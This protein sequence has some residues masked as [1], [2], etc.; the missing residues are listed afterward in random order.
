MGGWTG[1]GAK[2]TP[3]DCSVVIG[4]A[5]GL[6][7]A[8]G[9]DVASSPADPDDATSPLGLVRVDLL[10]GESTEGRRR[11]SERKSRE[12]GAEV[13]AHEQRSADAQKFGSRKCAGAPPYNARRVHNARRCSS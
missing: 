11:G 13:R 8:G 9:C 5:S 10:G 3:S 4:F 12:V 1:C 6:M 2:L 7:E